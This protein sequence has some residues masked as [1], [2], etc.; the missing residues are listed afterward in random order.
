MYVHGAHTSFRV[1]LDF[2]GRINFLIR[3]FPCSRNITNAP[4]ARLLGNFALF[5]VRRFC[6][7]SHRF[8]C[9]TQFTIYRHGDALRS[10][11]VKKHESCVVASH[12]LFHIIIEI[13]WRRH[14]PTNEISLSHQVIWEFLPIIIGPSTSYQEEMHRETWRRHAA[15]VCAVRMSLNRDSM[16]LVERGYIG[17]LQIHALSI[18]CDW[19]SLF[20]FSAQNFPD[21]TTN[22][23]VFARLHVHIFR[24]TFA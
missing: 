18:W 12:K 5:F 16:A 23:S 8:T 19:R 9:A 1:L 10:V 11:S 24:S 22:Q 13:K 15:K 14:T 7:A 21:H 3:S 17:Q 4:Q 20:A 6:V 2:Y